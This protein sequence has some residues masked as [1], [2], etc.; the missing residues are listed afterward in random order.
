MKA[1]YGTSGEMEVWAAARL[2]SHHVSGVYS[3]YLK[4]LIEI[5]S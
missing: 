4:S 5:L 3:P 1:L 2:I